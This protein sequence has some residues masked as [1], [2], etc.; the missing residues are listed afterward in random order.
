M[1]PICLLSISLLGMAAVGAAEAAPLVPRD[2]IAQA[3]QPQAAVAS[4]GKVYVTFGAGETIYCC[5]SKDQGQTFEKSVEIAHVPKLALGKRRGPRIAATGEFAVIT[6]ISHATG[7]LLSWRSTDGGRTW[8]GPVTISDQ[9]GVAREGLHAMACGPRGELYC[10]WLDLRDG[11]Q[12]AI[13]GASS[14]D[15]GQTWGANQSIY[16]SPSGAVCPCCHPSAVFDASG[17]LF[18]MWRNS[19]DGNRDMY[20]STSTDAGQTFSTAAKLGTGAWK[21]DACPMDGGSLAAING[22]ATTIWRRDRQVFTAVSQDN[23]EQKLGSGEQPWATAASD[24][25]YL[26][27]LTRRGGDLW[28]KRPHEAKP[29][30]LAAGASDPVIAAPLTAAGPVIAV[31]EVRQGKEVSIVAQAIAP[32]AR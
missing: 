9:P 11:K 14:S 16:H 13:A 26:V 4:D 32:S 20:L 25:A 15:G 3:R 31:W 6:A 27:W 28:L 8:S 24:G 12:M 2:A 21:L 5:V 1:R 23:G 17:R 29:I 7:D 30:K 22:S 10:V 19:L 18:V